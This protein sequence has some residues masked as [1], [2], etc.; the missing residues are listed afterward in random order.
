MSY[1]RVTEER[2]EMKRLAVFLIVLT[3][4]PL[5]V[6]AAENWTYAASEHFEVYT[7]AGAGT[8]REALNYFERV[9]DFYT[10]IFRGAPKVKDR[11]RLIIFSNDRQFAPYRPNPNV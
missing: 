10:F 11:T 7:T 4:S 5:N 9:Y 3:L 2:C 8:A 6:R 1:P